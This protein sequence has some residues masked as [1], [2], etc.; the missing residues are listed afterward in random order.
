MGLIEAGAWVGGGEGG[1]GGSFPTP[2]LF[3][4]W[5]GSVGFLGSGVPERVNLIP[6]DV[7]TQANWGPLEDAGD[8]KFPRSINLTWRKSCWVS[9]A[10]HE[11]GHTCYW[12]PLW[13]LCDP[14]WVSL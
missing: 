4:T 6:G 5:Q 3:C 1:A 9:K 11:L 13:A 8:L 12:T 14:A 2:S 10:A 7:M